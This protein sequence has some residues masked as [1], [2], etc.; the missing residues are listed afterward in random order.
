MCICL[1]WNYLIFFRN[2]RPSGT[3]RTTRNECLYH[4]ERVLARLTRSGRMPPLFDYPFPRPLVTVNALLRSPSSSSL[5]PPACVDR[6]ACRGT[7]VPLQRLA[8]MSGGRLPG[9]IERHTRR[10]LLPKKSTAQHWIPSIHPNASSPP[11]TRTM[12]Y[13]YPSHNELCSM[14]WSTTH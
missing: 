13:A 10:L 12:K 4:Q 6:R 11:L 1:L 8:S 5:H 7:D 2:L 14:I 3:R 9:L